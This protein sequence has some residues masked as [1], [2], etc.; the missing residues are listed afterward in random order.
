MK[1]TFFIIITIFFA[2][3]SYSQN[4]T[5]N[6][7]LTIN[8]IA[9]IGKKV[10]DSPGEIIRLAITPYLHTGGPWKLSSRDTKADAFLDLE[11]GLYKSLITVHHQGNVGIGVTNPKNKFEVNGIIR[12]KEVKIE[13]TGWADFVFAENYKLPTLAEVEKHI[14]EHKHLPNIPSEAEVTENGISVG[15]MQAKLLQKIEEL[16]LYVIEQNKKIEKQQ[17][18]IE[19]LMQDKK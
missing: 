12:A 10:S 3:N 19:E 13:A 7:S 15:E 14:K 9:I 2:I 5:I 17:T 11:Y 6:G 8:N 18:L 4:Q 16:T 1:K